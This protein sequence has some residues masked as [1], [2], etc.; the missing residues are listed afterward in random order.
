ML[1]SAKIRVERSG[2]GGY[3][4]RGRIADGMTRYFFDL[5]GVLDYLGHG[6]R[7]TGIQRVVVVLADTACRKLPPGAAYLS[8]YDPGRGA[9]V[10]VPYAL[11]ADGR[12]TDP[13]RLRAAFGIAP[14]RQDGTTALAKYDRRPLRA[15]FHAL[16]YRIYARLGRKKYAKRLAEITRKTAV[17]GRKIP[18]RDLQSFAGLANARDHLVIMDAVWGL[19][20]A[21]AAFRAARAR[22]VFVHT[23]LHDLIPVVM[24]E[25]MNDDM[26]RR[27]EPWLRTSHDYTSSYLAVSRSTGRDLSEFLERHGIDRPVRNT[28]LAQARVP[29]SPR[30]DG[31]HD[32]DGTELTTLP[33][34]GLAS[35]R[36]RAQLFH[37]YVLCVGTME[38]RKNSWRVAQAWDRLRAVDGLNL[39]RLVFVGQS[40]WMNHAF[41]MMMKATG[42]LGG[43]VDIIEKASDAE[44]ETLYRHCLFTITAS[45]YEGWGLPVGESLAYGK[46]GVVARTSSL[47]EV[48]GDL[49]EYC[50]PTSIDSIAQAC[51]TLIEDQGRRAALEARIA[52]APLRQW[53]DTADDLLA[54]L[55]DHAADRSA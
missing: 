19:E 37:P 13:D 21:L 38:I 30:R 12:L 40:G 54:A 20:D 48:G 53:T 18:A 35:Q 46:T 23:M 29:A 42:Q 9:Y 26:I 6:S 55:A 31:D 49:V 16:R 10:A 43:W 34:P 24:P 50:D 14:P 28:P 4:Q 39:P 36:V 3:G 27:F 15:A 8:W 44:L 17:V 7:F 41:E 33:E 2:G 11:L 32:E 45:R 22:G 5:S 47:P 52:T 25:V 51:R 1:P